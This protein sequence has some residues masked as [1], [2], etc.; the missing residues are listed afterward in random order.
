MHAQGVQRVRQFPVIGHIGCRGRAA[1]ALSNLP[2]NTE[3]GLA[4]VGLGLEGLFGADIA[5]GE[6]W[7]RALRF[8]EHLDLQTTS[9][10]SA[11]RELG[12]VTMA[13]VS[14]RTRPASALPVGSVCAIPV[15]PNLV[16]DRRQPWQPGSPAPASGVVCDGGNH[17]FPARR[18]KEDSNEPA[19]FT[20]LPSIREVMTDR[21][22]SEASS[23]PVRSRLSRLLL[24]SSPSGNTMRGRARKRIDARRTAH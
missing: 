7:D 6:C 8:V 11:R 20:Y 24:C 22:R 15:R 21:S 1:I 5:R 10:R 3:R 17:E 18:R 23:R 14:T 13:Y 4:R 2:L 16:G 9:Q 12:L 19:S